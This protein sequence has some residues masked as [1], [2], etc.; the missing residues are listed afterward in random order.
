MFK[1]KICFVFIII[2]FLKCSTI[3]A[4][5]PYSKSKIFENI[6]K[7]NSL[8]IIS[9]LSPN[10][11]SVLKDEDY[12]DSLSISRPYK[13]GIKIKEGNINKENFTKDTLDDKFILLRYKIESP[14][15][16]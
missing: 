4:E 2:V 7:E 6:V 1:I 8:P 11:D 13:F 5:I 16:N 3:K 12:K 15:A 14:K 10:I 9:L